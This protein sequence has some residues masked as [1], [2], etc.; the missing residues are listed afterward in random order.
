MLIFQAL[1]TFLCSPH[2]F[3]LFSVL[4]CVTQTTGFILLLFSTNFSGGF[5]QFGSISCLKSLHV[6]MWTVML[7]G[8]WVNKRHVCMAS[9]S[10]QSAV[11][12]VTGLSLYFNRNAKSH[13]T[14]GLLHLIIVMRRCLICSSERTHLLG[15]NIHLSFRIKAETWRLILTYFNLHTHRYCRADLESVLHFFLALTELIPK[16][17]LKCLRWEMHERSTTAAPPTVCW[18]LQK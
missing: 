17:Q 2:Q 18:S 14:F 3:H 13:M 11:Q 16:V 4:P 1:F 9:D 7:V 12:S 10:M 8:T 6:H 5:A 15:R